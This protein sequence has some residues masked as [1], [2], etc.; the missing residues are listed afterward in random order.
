MT[1]S[2]LVYSSMTGNADERERLEASKVAQSVVES[3]INAYDKHD[4]K[5]IS[6]LFVPDGVFLPPN[7]TY[8]SG[9]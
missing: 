6:M 4:P 7:G 3:Y 9:P 8:S 2:A 1:V 5:A